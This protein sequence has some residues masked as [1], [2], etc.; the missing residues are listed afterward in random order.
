MSVEISR[1][2][3]RFIDRV[4]GR[5]TRHAFSFGPHY[6]PARVSYGPL[7][8]HDDH[9]LGAGQGFEEHPH[10]AVEIVTWVV[11]GR[12]SHRDSLGNEAELGPGECGVLRA[13]AGVRHTELATTDGA[14]RFV[15]TWLA[16]DPEAE[17][18]YARTSAAPGPHAPGDDPVRLVGDGGP[19]AIGVDGASYDL[20][21]LGPNETVT[22][23]AA[24]RVHAFVV[25]GALLRSSLAEPL[26]AG[27][28][29]LLT[30][31]PAHEVTA[32]V[33]TELLVWSFG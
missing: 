9:L 30:D 20:V 8:C 33:P 12:L 24:P 19:L 5:L 32:G 7:V 15:Q 11:S 28:A 10:S 26:Q 17:P 18:A 22:L 23:P 29:F 4:P 13:G 16:A 2:S 27:D 21:R 3:S 14:V 31:E 1:G 25:T 6:D